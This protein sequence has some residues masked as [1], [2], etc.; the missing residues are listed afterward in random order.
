M[1]TRL[2]VLFLTYPLVIPAQAG[3]TTF[4]QYEKTLASLTIF[5]R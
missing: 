4:P 2:P 1:V 5:P 3:M